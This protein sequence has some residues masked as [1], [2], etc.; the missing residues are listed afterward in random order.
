MKMKL[1][2][3]REQSLTC[4]L[5]QNIKMFVFASTLFTV[6]VLFFALPAVRDVYIDRLTSSLE[7]IPKENYSPLDFPWAQVDHLTDCIALSINVPEPLETQ[8]FFQYSLSSPAIYSSGTAATGCPQL[9]QYLN[10][11][12]INTKSHIVDSGMA[13]SWFYSL[14]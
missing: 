8:Q 3:S 14:S 11:G 13:I 9:I 1:S 12:G 7:Q 10:T 5:I 6:L 2:R 4:I